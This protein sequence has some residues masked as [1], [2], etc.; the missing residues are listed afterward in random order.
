MSFD[1]DSY[2]LRSAKELDHM[3][4]NQGP[5]QQV[6]WLGVRRSSEWR[7]DIPQPSNILRHANQTANT[8]IFRLKSPSVVICMTP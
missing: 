5:K 4:I 2:F 6:E 8:H 3:L 7:S 1:R